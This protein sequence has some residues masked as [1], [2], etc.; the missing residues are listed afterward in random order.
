MVKTIKR[1]VTLD[2][3][4]PTDILPGSLFTGES[5]GHVFMIFC[6]QDAQALALPAG[7]VSGEFINAEKQTVA[8]TGSVVNGAA[9]L[10]LMPACYAVKGRFELTIFHTEGDS[11]TAIYHAEGKVTASGTDTAID[12]SQ[13]IASVS[14][15]IAALSEAAASIPQDYS[16]LSGNMSALTHVELSV[17][18]SYIGPTGTQIANASYRCSDFI[19][20][21]ADSV[22][23]LKGF[24]TGSAADSALA[25]AFYDGEKAFIS[26]QN[27]VT[28]DTT[29]TTIPSGAAYVRFSSRMS[30]GETPA[31]YVSSPAVRELVEMEARLSALE[32]I[33]AM[34]CSP[35]QLQAIVQTGR[36]DSFFAPGDMISIPWTDNHGAAPVEYRYPFV[37]VHIGDAYD[38]EN[39][40]HE[41][42][43]WLQ[44]LYATPFPMAFDAQEKYAVDLSQ[45]PSAL[46]GWYYL[47]KSGSTYTALNLSAGDPI[48]TGYD[49]VYKSQISTDVIRYGYN[50][51][52][53][54]CA[55]Q[56]LNSAAAKN[57]GWWTSQHAGDCAPTDGTE[58]YPGFLNGFPA[59]WRAIF[60][61]VRVSSVVIGSDDPDVTLDTFFLP[62]V[63]QM[64]G[65]QSS[66]AVMGAP[67]DYW[68]E[69]SSLSGASN[70]ADSARVV[71]ALSD[72]SGGGVQIWLRNPKAAYLYLG[73]YL[74]S[75]GSI[76]SGLTPDVLRTRYFQP[77]CVIY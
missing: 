49:Q 54:S 44:A 73:Y 30:Q 40:K 27:G 48:P 65:G 67:W 75:D 3:N 7:T 11:T 21:A 4:P 19:P 57:A 76:T 77:C 26:G 15:L 13:V 33:L 8:L 28:A 69:E 70:N 47:G 53:D 2:G 6:R 39:L 62:A 16:T 31:A 5:K 71:P 58:N 59:E 9:V 20:C 72:V 14:A 50:R 32:S 37:V 29:V 45:E 42:A 18:G 60:Q 17:A 46:S 61:P 66:A 74:N 35:A 24:W 10:P 64:Y 25:Y 52:K 1:I 68:E 38:A 22:L 34:D 43:L 51:W 41:K 12:Q 63:S 55:R 36:A 23:I 56:W